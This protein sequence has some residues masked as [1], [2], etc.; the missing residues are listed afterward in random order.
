MVG[1]WGTLGVIT[2]VHLRL[3]ARPTAD[4]T[5]LVEGATPAAMHGVVRGPLPPLAATLLSDH[6]T[7]SLGYDVERAWLVRL[8]GNDA[9]V[10]AARAAFAAAGTCHELGPESWDVV[11][12]DQAPEALATRWPWT[13]LMHRVRAAFDP[14]GVLN[15]GLLAAEAA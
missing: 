10:S 7:R 2:E 8:G 13:P 6:V 5:L 1:S 11:R 12:R 3:R 4:L 15:P 14:R 9:Q